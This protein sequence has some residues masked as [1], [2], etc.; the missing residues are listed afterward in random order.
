MLQ[1]GKHPVDACVA[2]HEVPDLEPDLIQTVVG[3]A[4]EIDDHHL[5]V[6]DVVDDVLTVQLE[7]L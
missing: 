4:L 6:D 7:S 5:A 3:P 2:F 1:P